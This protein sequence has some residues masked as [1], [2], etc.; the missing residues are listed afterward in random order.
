[1]QQ[2]QILLGADALAVFLDQSVERHAEAAGREQILAVAVVGKR[3][4]L[5]NQRGDDV[6]V[7]H[8]VLVP[9][10]QSRQRVHEPIRIPHLDA[11]REQPGFDRLADEPTVN[12]VGVAVNVDQAARIDPATQTQAAVEA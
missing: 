7:L 5:A 10:H 12:R 1:M 3:A 6:P 8:R 11:I 9:A 4:R 2:T